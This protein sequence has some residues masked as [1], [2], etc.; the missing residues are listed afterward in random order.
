LIKQGS[1]V[2]FIL[3]N[4]AL[5][6][7]TPL[8]CQTLSNSEVYFDQFVLTTGIKH[9]TLNEWADIFVIAPVTANVI[10]KAASGIG[11]DL[12]STTLLSF[13]KPV[14][15]V[16]AM[17][18]GMWD[19]PVVQKNVLFLRDAG[20][21]F[22]EPGV[23]ALASGKIGRGRFPSIDIIVKKIVSIQEKRGDLGKKKFLVT[24]GRT[25]EDLD[26]VR[27]VTNRS[28]GRMAAELMQAIYCRGGDVRGVFGEVTCE[29]PHDMEIS[30]VRTSDEM[31]GALR[32]NFPWCDCLIM[33]A[34]V[35]DY[36]PRSKSAVK[37]HDETCRVD[38]QKNIDLLKEITKY[39]ADKIVVGFSLEDNEQLSRARDKMRAKNLDIIVFNSTAAIGAQCVTASILKRT[40]KPVKFEGQTKW[41]MAN[42]ILDECTY[43]LTDRSTR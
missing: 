18:Q 23:G 22:L 40:G 2:R 36:R 25:E 32:D 42:R 43:Y 30:R 3:T 37:T 39:K 8:S 38:F 21:H 14:L 15:F 1:E 10:G 16:P 29:L 12:L 9:L 28:S 6:F 26:P 11:D 31:L 34:A 24:G 35:G 17:D 19:N 5:N 20:F 13:R 27:V 7:V 41:E 33:A 4:S